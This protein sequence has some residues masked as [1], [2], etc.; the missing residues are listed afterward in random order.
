MKKIIFAICSIF[1]VSALAHTNSLTLDYG[2]FPTTGSYNLNVSA[3]LRRVYQAHQIGDRVTSVSI[4]AKSRYGHGTV[5]L[6]IGNT[7]GSAYTVPGNSADFENPREWTFHNINL[8]SPDRHNRGDVWLTLNGNIVL[9]EVTVYFNDRRHDHDHPG[10]GHPGHPRPNPG[11]GD[12]IRS[13]N[14]Y[15]ARQHGN[16]A[17]TSCYPSGRIHRA[18]LFREQSFNACRLNE[19][20]GVTHDYIWVAGDCRADFQVEVYR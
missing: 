14:L 1:S 10:H 11:Y 16:Q 9:N 8:P 5:T 15:C 3:D 20:W 4:K 17:S 18:R 2:N 19:T 7:P 13:E 12:G 6:W